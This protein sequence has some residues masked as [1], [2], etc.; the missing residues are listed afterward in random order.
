[1]ISAWPSGGHGPSI[2][3]PFQKVNVVMQIDRAVSSGPVDLVSA[4]PPRVGRRAVAVARCTSRTPRVVDRRSSDGRHGSVVDHTAGL[5]RRGHRRVRV[6]PRARRGDRVPRRRIERAALAARLRHR[7]PGLCLRGRLL[8]GG[9]RRDGPI[10]CHAAGVLHGD[11]RPRVVRLGVDVVHLLGA[12]LD[13][14]VPA[15]RVQARRPGRSNGG[16]TSPLHHRCRGTVA[17][18][19]VRTVRRR[20]RHRSAQ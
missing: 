10:L 15:R 7:C 1:M 17:A 5:D 3:H 9:S 8:L 6:G 13:H 4:C 2:K 19:R 11:G 20:G 12:H 14:L 16:T 18:R